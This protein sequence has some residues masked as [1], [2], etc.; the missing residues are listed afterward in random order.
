MS[1]VPI[2]RVRRSHVFS[3]PGTRIALY[4]RR[5]CNYVQSMSRMIQIRNVPD[6]IH[7]TLKSR[8]ALAGMS[9]SDYLLK[10]LRLIA[11][12]PTME[13]MRRRLQ[14]RE[15]VVLPNPRLRWSA[16]NE[17]RGDSPRRLC[18]C[19]ISVAN[20]HRVS[21]PG[22]NPCRWGSG[23]RAPLAGRGG[24]AGR[25]TARGN[26]PN[27]KRPR[28]RG[29]RG[30]AEPFTHPTSSRALVIANLGAAPQPDRL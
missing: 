8:A 20:T 21:R 13:E 23:S 24:R 4:M 16:P 18:G 1:S 2:A 12:R 22:E 9:L 3:V 17:T 14:Q 5:A 15:P 27:L 10:E 29:G 19:R 7:R 30:S 11:E 6:S 25:Q 28:Q 26:W